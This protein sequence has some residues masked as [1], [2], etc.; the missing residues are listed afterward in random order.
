MPQSRIT[1]S[2]LFDRQS[3]KKNKG[4]VNFEVVFSLN[5]KRVWLTVSNAFEK[6]CSR[7]EVGKIAPSL[8]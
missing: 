2:D 5:N 3:R 1:L 8:H 4:V 6:L 7:H